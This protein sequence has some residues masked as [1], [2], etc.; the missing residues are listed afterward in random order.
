MFSQLDVSGPTRT[1]ITVIASSRPR[2]RHSAAVAVDLSDEA[3]TALIVSIEAVDNVRMSRE[4]LTTAGLE[5]RAISD[6]T[7]EALAPMLR[8]IQLGRAALASLLSI[9]PTLK[10]GR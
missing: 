4:I 5:T 6:T 2:G 9:S 1:K 10:T 7:A 3:W 8:D